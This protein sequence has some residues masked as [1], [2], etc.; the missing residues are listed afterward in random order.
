[1]KKSFSALWEEHDIL[2]NGYIDRSEAYN[3]VQ[4]AYHRG[5]WGGPTM[6]MNDN[7]YPGPMEV[8]E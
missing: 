4:D 8:G 7:T 3:L 5:D 1:M 2:K 6:S